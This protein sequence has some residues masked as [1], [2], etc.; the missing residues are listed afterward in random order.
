MGDIMN[1]Y[2]Y[3]DNY[4][5]YSFEEKDFNEVDSMIFSFITYTNFIE[6]FEEKNVLTINEMARINIGYHREKEKNIIAVKEGN[7]LLK[8]IKDVKRYKDCI[9]YNPEY[10]GNNKIQFGALTIEYKKENVFVAY[11]GT[12]QLFSGWKENFL[13]SYKF[14]TISHKLAIKYLNKNFTFSNKKIIVGGHSKGGN[15]ALVAAM[16]SNL[17]VRNKIKYIYNGDGPGL[18]DNEFNSNRYKK[19]RN[20]YLHIIPDYSLIGLLLCTSNNKVVKCKYKNILSHN[21]IEWEIEDNHF[22]ETTLSP[23]STDIEKNLKE[24]F[25]KYNNQDKEEFV[26]NLIKVLDSAEVYS[27][28]DIKEKHSK[29]LNIVYE[30]KDISNN[31][32]KIL[33]DFINII[34]KSIANTKKEEFKEFISNIFNINKKNQ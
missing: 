14:P 21:A 30:T 16:Y 23:M 17:F 3:I 28:I 32:K 29:I 34:I 24:W 12:N 11:E 7:K 19:I 25:Y 15:L 22:K 20:K 4:G 1:I 2:D 18:L 5:I 27:I 6:L 33:I 9:V 26:N 31:T 10:I 13:L 8:Y